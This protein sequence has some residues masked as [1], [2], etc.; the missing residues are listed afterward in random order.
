MI[1]EIAGLSA[2]GMWAISSLAYSQVRV[3]A[4]SLNLFKN[5]VAAAALGCQL[6][7][8]IGWWGFE[9]VH[10]WPSYF[11]L[12]LSALIGILVGDTFYF[13]S[14]QILGARLALILATAA[15]IFGALLGWL[16]LGES[17]TWLGYSGIALT[18][19]SIGWVVREK[20]SEE[21]APQLFPGEFVFGVICALA[22]ALCQALG[23]VTSKMGLNE[24]QPLQGS[25]VRLAAALAIAITGTILMGRTKSTVQQLSRPENLRLTVPAALVG[26][27]LGI[28]FSLVAAKHT[29]VAVST[30]LLATSPIYS[31]PLAAIVF[32]RKPS[33]R[34]IAG[35]ILAVV[36]VAILVFAS[37]SAPNE[38]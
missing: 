4:W 33:W 5:L 25:F 37:Q 11:W 36:G 30:T 16:V 20:G 21:E 31:L 35:T 7:I 18:M 6:L 27:W 38:S 26:A 32:R 1:G 2:A 34:A 12:S 8:L 28:W 19:L 10:H 14:I 29:H 24:C 17:T 9:W 22:A 23:M 15:P 3:D 13:R